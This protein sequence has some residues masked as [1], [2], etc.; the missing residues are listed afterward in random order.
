MNELRLVGEFI[1]NRRSDEFDFDLFVVDTIS[2]DYFFK[3]WETGLNTMHYKCL[4]GIENVE[5]DE[6]S[7]VRNILEDFVS[8]NKFIIRDWLK[9]VDNKKIISQNFYEMLEQNNLKG[10]H[11]GFMD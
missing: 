4:F 6:I 8:E 1:E 7:N 2:N 3:N 11:F 5:E 9:L 10:Y